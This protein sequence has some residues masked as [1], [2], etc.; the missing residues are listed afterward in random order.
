MFRQHR[1]IRTGFT[2]IEI[3]VVVVILGIAGAIIVPQL[4][5]R[6]DLKLTA[7]ARVVMADLI[8]TQNLAITQQSNHYVRFSKVAQNYSVFRSSDLSLVT[9]PVNKNPFVVALNTA[10][11]EGI[12]VSA[13]SFVGQSAGTSKTLGFDELGTPLVY[14]SSGVAETMSSG[15]ITFQ[16]GQ[17]QFRITVEP[18][19][20]QIKGDFVP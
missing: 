8:Y 3:L 15:A 9:H 17:F 4:S 18:Y 7:A 14:L 11:M 2:L 10:N 13:A 19:T 6:D 12:K 1:R 5:T 16:C 20:G